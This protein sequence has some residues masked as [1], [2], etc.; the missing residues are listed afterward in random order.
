V[1][2]RGEA[3]EHRRR[4]RSPSACRA[5]RRATGPRGRTAAASGVRSS[6]AFLSPPIALPTPWNASASVPSAP[7]PTGER[8]DARRAARARPARGGA[9]E[10]RRR[11]SAAPTRPIRPKPEPNGPTPA[12]LR[13]PAS[14]TSSS[15]R[16]VRSASS[17]MSLTFRLI[18]STA[19]TGEDLRCRDVRLGALSGPHLDRVQ[20][21]FG[22]PRDRGQAVERVL[23]PADLAA[24][25]GHAATERSDI[26][27]EV[28]A[29]LPEFT[30]HPLP[31]R[32]PSSRPT[33]SR[34]R[35]A[36]SGVATLIPSAARSAVVAGIG[37]PVELPSCRRSRA[38]MSLAACLVVCGTAAASIAASCRSAWRTGSISV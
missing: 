4:P 2:A 16:F 27:V 32:Q 28:V 22:D 3:G 7:A 24:G 11:R 21:L 29:R 18:R 34:P 17:P 5:S 37:R 14:L 31:L 9:G 6:N 36:R 15:F 33:S 13:P 35:A 10:R 8:R 23:C 38:K 19:D 25:F 26:D 1:Q 30:R 20:R 12:P